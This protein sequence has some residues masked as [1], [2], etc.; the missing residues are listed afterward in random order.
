[1]QIADSSQ[2][3]PVALG[4]V[5]ILS[6][7]AIDRFVSALLFVVNY[8]RLPKDGTKRVPTDRQAA[9]E[10]FAYY[11][12]AGLL[13]SWVVVTYPVARVM[14]TLNF[15]PYWRELDYFVSIVVILG[16]ADRI[17]ALAPSKGAVVPRDSGPR[18]VEIKGRVTLE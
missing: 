17:A 4:A 12:L 6:S 16:G 3:S 11:F 15:Y 18:P 8:F 7:F 5:L 13:A 14:H 10:K 9:K 1:M 2:A